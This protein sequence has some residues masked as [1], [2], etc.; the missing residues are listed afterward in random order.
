[1]AAIYGMSP[2]EHI[3]R[4]R[5]NGKTT[6]TNYMAQAMSP[7]NADIMADLTKA[8]ELAEQFF[9]QFKKGTNV[10]TNKD[11][12][13][14]V[15]RREALERAVDFHDT[16]IGDVSH[17][18]VLK[19]ADA[20]YAWL[21]ESDATE[22]PKTP[23]QEQTTEWITCGVKP[24]RLGRVVHGDQAYETWKFQPSDTRFMRLG[25]SHRVTTSHPADQEFRVYAV[26][27][28]TSVDH[29]PV[30]A[31][32]RIMKRRLISVLGVPVGNE[33]VIIG[34]FVLDAVK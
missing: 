24:F 27:R 19:T 8:A 15:N 6:A 10:P 32:Y 7:A 22:A 31:E 2:L 33:P 12:G 1:M 29:K 30:R 3:E 5:Q 11:H 20:F 13:S 23:S 34:A 16:G 18:D 9:N 26:K 25:Y 14:Y 28:V 4:S 21:Q 17:R